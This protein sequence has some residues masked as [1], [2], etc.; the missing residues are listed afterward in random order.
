MSKVEIE[1]AI[2]NFAGMGRL[3]ACIVSRTSWEQAEAS[4]GPGHVCALIPE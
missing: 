1:G 2:L 3:G 4:M